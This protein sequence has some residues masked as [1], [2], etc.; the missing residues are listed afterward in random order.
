MTKQTA[1]NTQWLLQFSNLSLLFLNYF[2]TFTVKPADTLPVK[3]H[4]NSPSPR[5][6]LLA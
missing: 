5:F 4:L 1:C 3:R 6:S 2:F